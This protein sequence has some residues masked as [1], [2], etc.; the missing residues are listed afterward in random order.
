METVKQRIE[1][2][3]R[4]GVFGK[5]RFVQVVNNSEDGK[6]AQFAS[7]LFFLRV[8]LEE[9][10]NLKRIPIIVKVQAGEAELELMRTDLQFANEV[11]AYNQVL[12]KLGVNEL[13]ICPQMYYGLANKGEN[14]AEDLIV[15]E[16][17]RPLGFKVADDVL[18]DFDHVMFSMKKLGQ[19]HGRSYKMKNSSPGVL[20]EL[21]DQF[22]HVK[23]FDSKGLFEGFA[24]R[25]LKPLIDSS[26]ADSVVS[27]AYAKF[28]GATFDEFSQSLIKPDE[29]FAVII[30]GDFNRNNLVYSYN[31]RNQVVSMKFLDWATTKYSN[32]AVDLSFFLYMNTSADLRA[33]HWDEF[34]EA[35]WTGV[36]SVEPNPGFSYNEF[37]KHFGQRAI[38]GYFITAFFLPMMLFKETLTTPEL[39]KNM[40][41]EECWEW[42]LKKGGEKVTAVT[43]S[44]A[45]HLLDRGYLEEYVSNSK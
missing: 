31:E 34:L 15:L 9:E 30:H 19:F 24:Y 10:G 35:Y 43:S 28:S 18:L 7:V 41:P 32:P 38:W 27:K 33:A 29:P 40:T 44:V 39:I 37:L 23:L 14:P 36:T 20:R 5:G 22:S 45:R 13:G 26:P 8:D 3:A 2:L 21:G 42:G 17:L 6:A 1:K 16:D 11:V 4:D 25:G 12:P